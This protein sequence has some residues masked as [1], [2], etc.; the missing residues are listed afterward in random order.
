MKRRR[1]NLGR[2]SPSD[3]SI[4]YFFSLRYF[5]LHGKSTPI[6]RWHGFDDA[7]VVDAARGDDV[8]AISIDYNQRHG[9]EL[10]GHRANRSAQ[11]STQDDFAR[12][13]HDRWQSADR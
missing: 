2:P 7:A 13:E 6:K 8:H 3:L 4:F 5:V 12:S 1:W 9:V 11:Y 10:Q